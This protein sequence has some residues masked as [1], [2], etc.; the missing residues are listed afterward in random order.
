MATSLSSYCLHGLGVHP[1]QIEVNLS[2]G[3][4]HFGI[5]GMAGTSVKEA[6]D[7]VRSAIRESG[8]DFPMVRKIVNLAPAD[9]Q[10]QGSHFDLPI[11]VGLLVESG[12]VRA[13]KKDLLLLGELGLDG[14]LREVCGVLPMLKKAAEQGF[15]KVLLP[16]GNL[17]EASWVEDLELYPVLSLKEVCEHLNGDE[18]QPERYLREWATHSWPW[19]FEDISG[20]FFAKRA[21][22]VAAAGG[23]HVLLSGPPGSGKSLLARAFPSILP[24]LGL[25]EILEVL[26]IHS[27]AGEPYEGGGHR[28]FRCVH[29]SITQMGLL[30]GGSQLKPGEMSLAHLGVLYL[31]ELAEFK[32]PI[33][34]LLRTPLEEGA[35]SLKRG[36]VHSRF[37]ASFQLIA[38]MNPCPCGYFGD[39]QRTC[40]CNS[41]EV[42]SYRGRISGPLLDRIDMKLH[43]PRIS[44]DELKEKKTG[45]SSAEM[46]E[47]V[48]R[49]REKQRRRFEGEKFYC[50]QA[51]SPKWVKKEFLD[52]ESEAY[53]RSLSEKQALSGRAVHKIIRVARSIADL[54]GDVQ[55]QMP[56][57]MEAAQYGWT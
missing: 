32:R 37:P 56:H 41:Y 9:L 17:A 46:R 45:Q 39:S 16:Q 55:I 51:M 19:D 14:G 26:E 47:R 57:L 34:E 12:E 3:M 6:A 13:P 38:A 33:L 27:V 36:R 2:R 42:E 54:E 1:V 25:K 10:K 15:K 24:A 21:L 48:Q 11:A 53:L 44:F 40:R 35:V 52:S 4:P 23:H 31:D 22:M 8:F 43:V 28:P 49:A 29:N 50:N 20:H 30:G 7:R 5:I 18:K